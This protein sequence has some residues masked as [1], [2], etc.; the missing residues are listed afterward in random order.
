MDP[1]WVTVLLTEARKHQLVPPRHCAIEQHIFNTP[2]VIWLG[3]LSR[4]CVEKS[5]FLP[6]YQVDC[7]D[8]HFLPR[9]LP[10]KKKVSI[11]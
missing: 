1:K 7:F 10:S 6:L 5:S 2:A 4:L 3:A 9:R 8:L 11:T